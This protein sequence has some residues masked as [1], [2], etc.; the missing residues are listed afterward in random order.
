MHAQSR[1]KISRKGQEQDTRYCMPATPNWLKLRP[2]GLWYGWDG[3]GIKLVA[4]KVNNFK[5]RPVM[6]SEAA[7]KQLCPILIS[8]AECEELTRWDTLS[9]SNCGDLTTEKGLSTSQV[10]FSTDWKTLQPKNGPRSIT[11]YAVRQ[12]TMCCTT[13]YYLIRYFSKDEEALVPNVLAVRFHKPCHPFTEE[14][15]SR[16]S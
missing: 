13:W 11:L 9:T 3:I 7:S 2:F 1:N 8:D 5:L 6:K 10:Y 15:T 14:S 4:R 12:I 16:F